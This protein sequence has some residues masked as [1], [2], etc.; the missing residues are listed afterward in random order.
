MVDT[1]LGHLCLFP[2][3]SGHRLGKRPQD[4]PT[5][6]GDKSRVQPGSLDGDKA[7]GFA[8]CAQPGKKYCQTIPNLRLISIGRAAGAAWRYVSDLEEIHLWIIGV[9]TRFVW[10]KIAQTER[11]E[12]VAVTVPVPV[13]T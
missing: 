6:A 8:E 5:M 1:P 3:R 7:L 13:F 10:P 12:G 4:P 11:C 2:L 9:K